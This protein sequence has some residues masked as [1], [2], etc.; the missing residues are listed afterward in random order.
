MSAFDGLHEKVR[1]WIWQQG[2]EGLRDVQERSIPHLLVGER[3]LIIMAATAGGKTE[4]AFLPIVSRL[5][6]DGGVRGSGFQAIYIRPMRALINDQFGRMESL[7][8]EMDI[9][10][11]K[12]YGD[13]SASIK[14]K[15]S[16]KPSGIM[17]ITPESLEAILVRRGKEVSRLFRGL[18]YVV[19]D[20]MHVFLDDPRGKQLQS[21]LHRIDIAANVKPIRVGLSATL[22]DEDAA[23]A[24]LRPLELGRVDVL[25]PGP[26]GPQIKL[27]LRGYIKPA[28]KV[29]KPPAA[30]SEAGGMAVPEDPASIALT[31]HLFETHRGHRS[32]IFAGS[33]QNVEL[34]TV[35][36]T[37]MT[38]AMG[39]PDEFFAHHGNLPREHREHTERRMKD[40]SR[41]AS[42]IC[43]TTLELGI[44]VGDIEAV[45]Q[46]GPGH[47]VSGMRQRLERSGRRPGH[48]AVM[49]V[50]VTESELANQTHPLDAL[51]P[52]TV[53]AIAMIN[54]MLRRWNEPDASRLHL[55]T[56]LH[57]VMA[58][59]AEHGG[60]TAARAWDVLVRSG[61]FTGVDIGLFK[62]LLRRMGNPEVGLLEQALDGT[63]LPGPAGE[64]LLEGRDIFA[65]FMSPEEYKVVAEG[66]RAVGQV[67]GVNPFSPGQML[68][69][70]GRRW[71][72]IEVNGQRR[73]LTVRPAH[74][75]VPQSFGGEARPL[76]DG[77]V[78]EMRRF[79]ED[80]TLPAFVDPTAQRL[81]SE[82]RTTYDRLG[83]RHSLIARH[84]GQLLL[85]PWV[86][87]KK[88]QALV[89]ALTNADLEPEPLG[90]AI[91]VGV[92]HNASLENVLG[93]LAYGHVPSAVELA[94][95][96]KNKEVEKFDPFLGD[97][98]LDQAWAQ[99]C[100]DVSSL[101]EIAEHLIKSLQAAEGRAF[102]SSLLR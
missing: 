97:E 68:I 39:V 89:L 96:V 79:W 71:R 41:P 7:C 16:K 53:Q 12:C 85:F 47:T 56:L 58:L 20:E 61:T 87:E 63:L 50:Y 28:F 23:R 26:G 17:L 43:T 59:V 25:P 13:V 38:E 24:F 18:S 33:R 73:E 8:S 3:D 19:I 9:E 34:T 86:G 45:A 49:R 27:Q 72:V 22:A 95:M 5:A 42:I 62:T 66:G 35:R 94:G 31:R 70:A 52:Q 102:Q 48:A 93:A 77:V 98:L 2:W 84:K 65:V 75:G 67:P 11:I 46:I 57:Q 83:L 101:P 51:R 10:V 36:L 40:R 81:V 1:R 99:D 74:G 76:A 78:A 30:P 80:L 88:Q 60:V 4:A 69:L 64:R 91:G 32:L 37:E 14:A 29:R 15:A 54:L 6:T 44:D 82:A 90:I 55:S 100:L 21:I 92:E